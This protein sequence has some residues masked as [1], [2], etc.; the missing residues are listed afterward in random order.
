MTLIDSNIIIYAAKPEYSNLRLFI[1]ED[2]PAVS[3]VSYV[4][5]LGYPRLSE[6]ERRH[7]EAF[8]VSATILPISDGVIHEAVRLRQRRKMTLG[9]A[10]VAGTALLHGLTLV[11]RNTRD[12]DWIEGL[13]LLNPFQP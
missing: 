1:A 8:F 3:A 7:F 4:E 11:T 2:A 10:L 6:E 12:F 5:V 9:D 13:P